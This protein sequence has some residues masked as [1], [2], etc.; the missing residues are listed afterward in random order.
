MTDDKNRWAGAFKL[1]ELT[2]EPGDMTPEN[3]RVIMRLAHEVL[4]V[5]PPGVAVEYVA[6][7][8]RL[9]NEIKEQ[10]R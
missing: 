10:G 7:L 9:Y 5:T 6:Q 4:H 1:R 8:R 2:D 3:E